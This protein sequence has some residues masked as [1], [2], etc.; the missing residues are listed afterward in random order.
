MIYRLFGSIYES[1][2]K[3]Y[4]MKERDHALEFHSCTHVHEIEAESLEIAG[5][6]FCETFSDELDSLEE[7]SVYIYEIQ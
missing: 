1:V 4:K 7:R 3:A 6:I 5:R 2:E